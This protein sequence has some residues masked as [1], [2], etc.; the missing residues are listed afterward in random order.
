MAQLG[1][2]FNPKN[3]N[4]EAVPNVVV[5]PRIDDDEHREVK[6]LYIKAIAMFSYIKFDFSDTVISKL[7]LVEIKHQWLDDSLKRFHAIVI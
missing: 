3:K 1:F 4:R 2:K 5:K 6:S 7:S